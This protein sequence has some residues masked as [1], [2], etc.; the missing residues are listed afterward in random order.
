M[1]E[2]LLNAYNFRYACKEFNTDKKISDVDFNTILETGRLSPSSF[3]WEPWQFLVIQNETV[4]AT[5]KEVTWGAQGTLPTA[6][7]FVIILS[8]KSD[9]VLF[10]SEYLRYMANDVQKLPEDI[11][12]MKLD[13]FKNFHAND[14][15]VT[16][17][18]ERFDWSSKQSY[19]PLGNMMTTAALLGI[20]SCPIEGF[21]REKVEEILQNEGIVDT[22][23]FGVSV[24]VA[25]GYRADNQEIFPKTRR[26]LSDVVTFV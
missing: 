25:F 6:S 12:T 19:I 24:M 20:D 3:G 10:D 11:Q 5:L 14:F 1:R 7:H 9:E 26:A 4:R 22:N 2:Q 23:K 13:F 18:R 16:T 17:N 15:D 21:N 8:R